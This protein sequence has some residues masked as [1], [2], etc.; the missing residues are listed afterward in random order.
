L[1]SGSYDGTVRIWD[2]RVGKKEIRRVK[3]GA[4]VEKVIAH[5]KGTMMVSAGGPVVRVWD[6]LGIGSGK[7]KEKEVLTLVEG[8]EMEDVIE[9][10]EEPKWDDVTSVECIRAMSN[11]QKTV[12]SLVCFSTSLQQVQTILSFYRHGMVMRLVF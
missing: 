10:E 9:V 3:H 8:E 7:G 5:P 1:I 6:L 4:P 12:T 2:S 11:H